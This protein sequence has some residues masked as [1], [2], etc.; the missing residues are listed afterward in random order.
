MTYGSLTVGLLNLSWK[1]D[2]FSEFF[3]RDEGGFSRNFDSIIFEYWIEE[4][5]RLL[6]M[7]VY[8]DSLNSMSCNIWGTLGGNQ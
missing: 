1:G 5:R 2:T 4:F 7:F 8:L 6:W 3:N